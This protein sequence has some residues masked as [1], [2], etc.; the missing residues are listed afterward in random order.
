MAV[1]ILSVC[2]CVCVL[3][4]CVCA[5]VLAHARVRERACTRARAWAR[6][7]TQYLTKYLTA[8]RGNKR[9]T[10]CKSLVFYCKTYC[11]LNMFQAP[12]CTSSG[13]LELYRWLLPVVCVSLVYRSLVWCGAVGYVSGLQDTARLASRAV[14]RKPD[15]RHNGARDRLSKQ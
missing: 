9:P 3:C 11:L 15:D 4:V 7:H 1:A 13:A 2:V 8:I 6:S 12:L 10:T 5:R 14:S